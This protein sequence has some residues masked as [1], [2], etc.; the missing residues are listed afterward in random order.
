[1]MDNIINNYP[2]AEALG[3]EFQTFKQLIATL[4]RYLRADKYAVA[5]GG[6]R[7]NEV[8]LP[9]TLQNRNAPVVTGAPNIKALPNQDLKQAITSNITSRY[10]NISST[11][12]ITVKPQ[13]A[14][15][16]FYQTIDIDQI[17]SFAEVPEELEAITATTNLASL[18]LTKNDATKYL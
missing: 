6:N 14:D 2:L 15:L 8:Y 9:Y 3:L 13:F 1:M 11:G 18:D 12:A 16:G 17:I 4:S 7:L 10:F 5:K